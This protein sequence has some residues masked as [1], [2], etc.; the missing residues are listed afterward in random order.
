MCVQGGAWLST[1]SPWTCT[2][3]L[4]KEVHSAREKALLNIGRK[5]IFKKKSFF[6]GCKLYQSDCAEYSQMDNAW[7]QHHNHK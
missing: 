4:I 7:L 1:P 2:V 5:E 3:V 6:D